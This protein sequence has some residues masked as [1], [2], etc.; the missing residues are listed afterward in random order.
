MEKDDKLVL[1]RLEESMLN[2]FKGNI[3]LMLFTAYKS[4]TIAMGL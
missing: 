3:Y 1:T 2:V 4:K